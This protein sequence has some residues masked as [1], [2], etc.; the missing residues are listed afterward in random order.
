MRWPWKRTQDRAT[1]QVGEAWPGPTTMAGV[2]VGPDSALRLAAVWACVRIISDVVSTLPVDV[3]AAETRQPVDRPSILV[4]PAAF[5]PWHEWIGQVMWSV[6]LTGNAYG[7]IAARS[8]PGMQPT[9]IELVDPAR[10]TVQ[11]DTVDRMTPIYRFDGQEIRRGD[12]LWVFPG[13]R[14]PGIPHGLSPVRY[15]AE[16]IGLGIAAG[17]YGGS[18]FGAEGRPGGILT[19]DKSLTDDE[20][21]E[22][23]ARWKETMVGVRRTA[24]LEHGISYQAIQLPPEEAQFLETQQWTVQQCAMVFGVPPELIAAAARGESVTYS[25]IE[26]RPLD[27]LKFGVQPWLVRL[28]AMLAELLPRGMVARFDPAGLLRADQATRYEAYTQ[29]LAAGWL[30][31]A[32]VRATEGLPPLPAGEA[33]PRLEAVQ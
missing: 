5:T 9:Q 10:V 3:L 6:L 20:L 1:W 12:P 15:H 4:R 28:E 22:L 13:H 23:Q 21:D 2:P 17:R 14:F 29:A 11:L 8:G 19:T 30:T 7:L 18:F 31:I 16:A 25:N 24:L 26:N 33:P 32:E 27:L